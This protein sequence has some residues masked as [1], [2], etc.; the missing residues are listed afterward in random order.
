M[1]DTI[2]N[3]PL[4]PLI[5]HATEVAVPVT[6]VVVILA[7]LWPRFRRWAGWAPLALSI[8][9]LV[10]VPLST[11]SGEALEERVTETSDLERHAQLGEGLIGWVIGLL[12]VAAAMF[13]WDLWRRR[14][15]KAAGTAAGAKTGAEAASSTGLVGWLR[16]PGTARLVVIVLAV[17][18]VVVGTGTIVQAVMIGH[19][20]ATAAVALGRDAVEW[21]SGLHG[22]SGMLVLADGV[23]HRWANAA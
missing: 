3:L 6:A 9:S 13:A 22:T 14:E 11:Q 20:G 1:L 18:G 10:L 21:T 12:L 16:L 7:V 8:A 23:V 19:S 4:H 17:A 2:G 15:A 5:V